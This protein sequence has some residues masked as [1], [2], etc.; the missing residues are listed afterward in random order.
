MPFISSFF[1][2]VSIQAI[3]YHIQEY[4]SRKR[5]RIKKEERAGMEASL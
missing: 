1:L 5:K 2:V 4:N 3:M